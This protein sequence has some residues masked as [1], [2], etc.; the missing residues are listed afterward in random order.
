MVVLTYTLCALTAL[1]CSVLLFR[2]YAS[3]R[4][5]LL[6]WSGMCFAGLTVN[7]LLVVLDERVFPIH[8]LAPW[9]IG[10]GVLSL[11]ILIY[12][13]VFGERT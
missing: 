11:S 9:R 4:V 7:N 13:L 3:S 12:G 5:P 8:D 1:A 10:V 2:G 6:F